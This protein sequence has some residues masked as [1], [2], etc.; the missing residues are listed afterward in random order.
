MVFGSE[1]R[2]PEPTLYELRESLSSE[3]HLWNSEHN[4]NPSLRHVTFMQMEGWIRNVRIPTDYV[5]PNGNVKKVVTPEE[6]IRFADFLLAKYKNFGLNYLRSSEER[7]STKMHR[8]VLEFRDKWSDAF[9][10]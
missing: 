5:T 8:F 7:Y 3:L 9:I 10:Y 1:T 6:I 2:N 4:W